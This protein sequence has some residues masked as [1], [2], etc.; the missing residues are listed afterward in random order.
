MP[1]YILIDNNSGF[2]F[3]DTA[4]FGRKLRPFVSEAFPVS[5]CE[6]T[7]A[8]AARVLDEEIVGEHGRSYVEMSYAPG[9][10]RT[11]YAVYRAD[12]NGSEAVASIIDGQ[13]QEMIDAV[14]SDCDFVCF[15]ECREG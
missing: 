14:E 9:D 6:L 2:I 10:T 15:V 1:R 12:I 8:Q 11:G 13:D 7:P 5:G 4:D 3:G